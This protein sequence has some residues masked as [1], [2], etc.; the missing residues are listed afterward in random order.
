MIPKSYAL[1]AVVTLYCLSCNSKKNNEM[2]QS[3]RMEPS[4][5]IEIAGE[6]F[7]N[8]DTSILT[9]NAI[10]PQNGANEPVIRKAIDWDKKIIKTG[11]LNA[12]VNDYKKFSRTVNEKI[13]KYGGYISS[14]E[15]SRSEYK[16]ENTMVVKVP[17]AEFENAVNDLLDG[18]EKITAKRITTDDVTTELVDGKSRLET[19]R[20]VRLK[21]LDLLKQ[22]KNMEE[23]IKVQSEVNSIQEE[24]EMAAGRIN[25]LNT[26]SAMSTIHFN[27]AQILDPT[28][29]KKDVQSDN[30]LTKLKSSF[31]NGW[32]WIAEIFIAIISIWP[33][34]LL[35]IVCFYY[36]KRKPVVKTK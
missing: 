21:Y 29:L 7:Q 8:A 20:Q 19:K 31:S 33:L 2:A 22:A 16:I 12:E 36:F 15:Q 30:F 25:A 23:I 27:Y 4:R 35:G 5:K 18:V 28:A 14:E 1:I 17:V 24:I 26:T 6:Q 3:D 32:Y 10:P 34:L 9:V 13:K 11:H